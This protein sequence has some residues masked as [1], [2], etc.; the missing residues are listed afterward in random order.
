MMYN[1][2]KMKERYNENNQKTIQRLL[3]CI[4]IG[5]FLCVRTFAE[6]E[7]F[8]PRTTALDHDDSIYSANFFALY[9]TAMPNCTTY[10]YGHAWEVLGHEPDLCHGSSVH[11][12]QNDG[13][14]SN[15][16]DCC[17]RGDEPRLGA[18]ARW[19][20]GQY[21]HVAVVESI[22]GDTVTISES[23]SVR[24]IYWQTR[25]CNI[26]DMGSGFQGYIYLLEKPPVPVIT[27]VMPVETTAITTTAVTTSVTTTTAKT[28][29]ITTAAVTELSGNQNTES[30]NIDPMSVVRVMF[31]IIIAAVLIVKLVIPLIRR[32]NKRK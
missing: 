17:E 3:L 14:S 9:V 25:T 8:I 28:T 23:D 7:D 1:L 16:N 10:A 26:N 24:Q 30:E 18:I 22:D 6:N 21:G 29:A 19:D 32:M 27:E 15:P 20:L 13:V 5:I 11:W 2:K 4:L 12:F 31:L